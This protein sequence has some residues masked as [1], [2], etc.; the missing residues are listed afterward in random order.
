M[1]ILLVGMLVGLQLLM[2]FEAK[3][4]VHHG[5]WQTITEI[6]W[7]ETVTS[8]ELVASLAHCKLQG[9]SSWPS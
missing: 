3:G 4:A 1:Q 2:L 6:C 5:I 8:C 7:H 9:M